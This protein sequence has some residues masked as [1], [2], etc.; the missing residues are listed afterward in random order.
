MLF[1]LFYENKLQIQRKRMMKCK[2][3]VSIFILLCN[4][5]WNFGVQNSQYKNNM[6]LR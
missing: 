2:P 5:N 3:D 1:V 6:K 4:G